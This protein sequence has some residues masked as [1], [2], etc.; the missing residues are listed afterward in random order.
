MSGATEPPAGP[1]PRA[2]PPLRVQLAYSAGGASYTIVERLL[3]LWL[4]PHVLDEA[5]PGHVPI[6]ASA[7]GAILWAGRITDAIFD[8][9]IA[10][11]SD[12]S[13]ARMGRRRAFLAVSLAPM[14]LLAALLF[15]APR[16]ASALWPSLFLGVVLCGFWATFT[17]Y[18]LPYLALMSELATSHATR[19]RLATLKAATTMLGAI[20]VFVLSP[21]LVAPLGFGGMVAATCGCALILGLVPVLGVDEPRYAASQPAT[22][23]LL[24]S[25]RLTLGD[26]AFRRY[27]VAF[28]LFWLGF[29]IV[30]TTVKFYVVYLLRLEES[31]V[32]GLMGVTF[33]SA[34]VSFALVNRLA[35][36]LGLRRTFS[37]CLVLFA[38]VLPLIY[39]FEAP[40]FGLPRA[41]FAHVVMGLAGVPLAGLFVIPDAIVSRLSRAAAAD[42]RE[43]REGMYFGVQGFFVKLAFGLSGSLTGLLFDLFGKG[44]STPTLG[45]RLT[46]PV[47]GLLAA[48][49]FVAFSRI[50]ATDRERLD[51]SG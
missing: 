1:P 48:V 30:T 34:F 35:L 26:S 29:N 12:R 46:G 23:S 11:L 36:R 47:A 3:N 9:W 44:G 4:A 28:L 22:T 51:A 10:A 43:G 31:A 39:F 32:G 24:R 8:P 16:T 5:S 45:L 41:A 15:F 14:C 49:G 20:C 40:P 18:A 27:L 21:Y 19:V 37:V 2:A 17:G 25:M 6:S 38:L 7:F 33:G 42:D 13:T 50:S